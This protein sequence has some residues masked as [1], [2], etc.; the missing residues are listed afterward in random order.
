[1][2]RNEIEKQIQLRKMITKNK[3]NSNQNNDYQI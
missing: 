2:Q 1:M 3:T